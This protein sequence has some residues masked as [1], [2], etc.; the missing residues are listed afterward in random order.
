VRPNAE[1]ADG[2]EERLA[3]F[4][5]GTAPGETKDG[6]KERSSGRKVPLGE[7]ERCD[8]IAAAWISAYMR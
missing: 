2:D 7:V 8:R 4:G 1:G 6:Q 3:A 5:G